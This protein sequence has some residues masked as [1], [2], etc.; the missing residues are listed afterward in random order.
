MGRDT[1]PLED[2]VS[3]ISHEYLLEFTSEYYIPESLHPELP[4]PEKP[5]VEFPE[6]KVGVY[7]KFFNLKTIVSPF[8]N[9]SLTS[10]VITKFTF[11]NYMDLFSLISALNPTKVKTGTHH[12]AAYEVPLLT[13]TASRVIDMEDTTAPVKKRRHKRAKDKAK[14]KALPKVLRK[15]HAAFRPTQSTIRGKS[16]APL[17]LDAGSTIFQENGHHDP[18]QKCCYQEGGDGFSTEAKLRTRVQIAEESQSQDSQM[19]LEDP[20]EGR[21]ETLLEAEVDMKEAAKAKNAKLAKELESLRAIPAHAGSD[22]E[23]S[24]GYWAR[25]TP[26]HYEVCLVLRTKAGIR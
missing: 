26:G 21:R 17:G 11:H 18:L 15:D 19:G 12:R 4:R 14:A 24:L 6:G 1:I 16:L 10:L 9:S 20:S 13:T 7:T 3:T 22:H 25:P 23:S 8:H 2:A 5:I